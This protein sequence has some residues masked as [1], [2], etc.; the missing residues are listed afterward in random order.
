MIFGR[1]SASVIRCEGV[2]DG[3]TATQ[4]NPVFVRRKRCG[5][6]ID[7]L[8]L[9]GLVC[10]RQTGLPSDLYRRAFKLFRIKS[11]RERRLAVQ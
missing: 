7:V 4:A 5:N 10:F 9:M 3:E 6:S 1:A 11:E 8:N 2:G